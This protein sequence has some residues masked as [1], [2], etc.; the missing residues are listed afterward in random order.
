[1]VLN[2]I[3]LPHRFDRL[4]LLQRELESEN[5]T[6]VRI[7]GGIICIENP[8]TGISRAHKQVV[9]Y[10]MESNLPEILIGE[11]DLHFSSRGAFNYF[12]HQKPIEYDLYLGGLSGGKVSRDKLVDDF[13]GLLLYMVHARFYKTFL[14]IDETKNLDRALKFHGRYVVCDPQPVVEHEGYSDNLKAFEDFHAC[15]KDRNLFKG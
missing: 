2:I 13:S 8:C 7:W 5:I 12:M 6:E 10:A 11:D 4:A 3:H 14:S 1:M 9:Q 15:F